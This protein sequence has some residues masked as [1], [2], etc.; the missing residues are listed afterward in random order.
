MIRFRRIG[1]CLFLVSL[2]ILPA[3]AGEGLLRLS[4]MR[5]SMRSLEAAG[6]IQA[7]RGGNTAL[8]EYRFRLWYRAPDRFRTEI[9]A[10]LAGE[11]L[12]V[13]DGTYVW[14]S[15]ARDSTVYRQEIAVY[16]ARRGSASDPITDLLFDTT[17]LSNRFQEEGEYRA[18]RARGIIRLI[19]KRG[20]AEYD[21]IDIR[22]DAA[23][24]RIERIETYRRNR[25]TARVRF[26]SFRTNAPVGDARFRFDPGR[27]RVGAVR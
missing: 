12:T 6:R 10:G 2:S 14:S 21:R 8:E 25:L 9:Q 24:L 13:S 18:S 17:P 19:P 5:L 22:L 20:A 15:S 4:S 7:S 1:A 27:R 3:R 11:I 26:D 23:G 16:R